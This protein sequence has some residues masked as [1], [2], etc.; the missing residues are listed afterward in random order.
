MLLRHYNL[1][2]INYLLYR[3]PALVNGS[4]DFAVHRFQ[5]QIHTINH[6]RSHSP[7]MAVHPVSPT[8]KRNLKCHPCSGDISKFL[9][10]LLI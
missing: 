10:V 1:L 3:L 2:K 6:K 8:Q 4:L 7:F 9:F 5:Q